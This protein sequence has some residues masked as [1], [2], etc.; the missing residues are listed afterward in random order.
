MDACMPM[1]AGRLIHHVDSHSPGKQINRPSPRA[2]R[3]CPSSWSPSAPRWIRTSGYL[4][5]MRAGRRNSTYSPGHHLARVRAGVV[6][7][8]VEESALLGKRQTREEGNESCQFHGCFSLLSCDPGILFQPVQHFPP[9]RVRRQPLRGLKVSDRFS[10]PFP[11]YGSAPSRAP[12]GR[13]SNP[14][15]CAK[16]V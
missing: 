4:R 6:T 11:A 15:R 2:R 9:F 16:P 1:A 3:E 14:D 8:N 13:T 12:D 7:T 10:F 5:V